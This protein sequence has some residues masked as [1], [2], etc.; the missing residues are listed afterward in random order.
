MVR[1]KIGPIISIIGSL[2]VI[3]FNIFY[4]IRWIG[5]ANII[6]SEFVIVHMELVYI[7]FVTAL[8]V[9]AAGIIGGLLALRGKRLS[10]VIPL[11][12]GLFAVVGIFIPIGRVGVGEILPPI[13]VV[14]TPIT[15]LWTF[16]YIDVILV[17]LGGALGL[18][19]KPDFQSKN[20]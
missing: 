11:S 13:S 14:W 15:L 3:G 7:G 8:V 1:E 6:G 2:L 19:L 5:E 12:V 16:I 10:N 20:A 4:L 17:F 18:L 9:G